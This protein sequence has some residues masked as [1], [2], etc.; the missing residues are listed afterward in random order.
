ML[1][2]AHLCCGGAAL[3]ARLTHSGSARSTMVAAPDSPACITPIA[4]SRLRTPRVR[5]L[6]VHAA[7]FASIVTCPHESHPASVLRPAGGS[8]FSAF[9]AAAPDSPSSVTLT[10]RSRL[11]TPVYVALLFT[12]PPLHL[13]TRLHE[14][15]PASV[16]RPP[17]LAR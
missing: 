1:R 7:S 13:V 16:L 6:A 5:R 9:A 8:R 15:H 2:D 10:A 4:G 14:S 12:L 17:L 11:R 3:C